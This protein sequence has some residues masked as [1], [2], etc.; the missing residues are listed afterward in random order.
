MPVKSYNNM[1][2]SALVG[3]DSCVTTKK[4]DNTT[5]TCIQPKTMLTTAY[6]TIGKTSSL[7]YVQGP[8]ALPINIGNIEVMVP[9][10]KTVKHST[11]ERTEKPAS[12]SYY[13][14]ENSAYVYERIRCGAPGSGTDWIAY[15]SLSKLYTEKLCWLPSTVLLNFSRE[16]PAFC[17][18][19]LLNDSALLGFKGSFNVLTFIAELKDVRRLPDLLRKWTKSSHDVS[20]KF[21]GVNFGLLPFASDIASIANRVKN[22]GPS[23]DKWNQ[24]AAKC[25]VLNFHRAY[26]IKGFGTNVGTEKNPI[27]E[28]TKDY[29]HSGG[30]C[31]CAA[32][33]NQ[34]WVRITTRQTLKALVHVYVVPVHIPESLTDDIKREVWGINKPI[35]ALWNAIPFSF[36]V[37][38]FTSLGDAIS[39]FEQAKPN[40]QYK[41]VSSG[42]SLKVVTEITMT[43]GTYVGG[44]NL[45]TVVTKSTVYDRVPI[46]PASL[47]H[48]GVNYSSLQFQTLDQNQA[49]LGSALMHQLLR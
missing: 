3:S 34:T 37:D 49:L 45:G 44:D 12:L 25:K 31:T 41:I 40:L 4:S 36:V 17:K 2:I 22:L 19:S 32:P 21:L 7:T 28:S 38:W 18:A 42:Y 33:G 8:K 48:M 5:V 35:T 20:D 39:R 46:D 16:A 27:W 30:T 47:L 15:Y 26:P 1:T 9:V 14:I 43:F 6:P 24:L 10:F 11:V 29:Y 23:I 13:R